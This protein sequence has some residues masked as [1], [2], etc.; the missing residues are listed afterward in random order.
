[1]FEQIIT[2]LKG[3]VTYIVPIIALIISILSYARSSKA[4][5]ME[6][7]L[8][9][10]ELKKIEIENRKY[11][12]VEGKIIY[13]INTYKIRIF[14]SGNIPAYQ[15]DYTIPEKYHIKL[16]KDNGVTPLEVLKPGNYFEEEIFISMGSS[17]K[18]EIITMWKDKDGNGYS[19]TELQVLS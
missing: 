14:N 19:N 8:N 9:E 5:K 18:C 1:M 11:A 16:F 3:V 6:E 7:K 2:V 13:G 17:A 10:Y 15:V 4:T 12:K